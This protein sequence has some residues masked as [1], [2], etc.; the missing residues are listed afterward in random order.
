MKTYLPFGFITITSAILINYNNSDC[1]NIQLQNDVNLTEYIRA[2][3]YIQQQ[4]ING[5]QP[6]NDLYCVT[7]T[8]N[9]DNHSHVPLFDGTVLSVYNY[10][11]HNQV[12]GPHTPVN[13]YSILCARQPNKSHPEKLLVAPCFLPNIFGGPYWIVSAGPSSDN[14]E[15]AIVSG[16]NPNIRIDNQTCTTSQRGINGSGLWIFSR[17]QTLDDVSLRYIRNL[18]TK[19]GISTSRLLNVTQQGCNYTGAFIKK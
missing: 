2:T 3:W 15:W 18:L 6:E 8:Y 10:A 7:A 4:Q 17:N 5:Y 16:G 19:K 14:Y 1:P 9:L 13:N 11:N 12:N